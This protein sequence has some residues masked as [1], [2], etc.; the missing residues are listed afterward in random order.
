MA[1]EITTPTSGDDQSGGGSTQQTQVLGLDPGQMSA[2][3]I[4]AAKAKHPWWDGKPISLDRMAAILDERRRFKSQAEQLGG[5]TKEL[6]ELRAYRE[7]QERKG[8]TEIENLQAD[9]KKQAEER[10]K[11][12]AENRALRHRTLALTHGAKNPDFAQWYIE[13]EQAKDPNAAPEDIIAKMA[14]A[15]PD[16]F[17]TT[18]NG[19]DTSVVEPEPKAAAQGGAG[20]SARG[21]Q[22]MTLVEVEKALDDLKKSGAQGKKYTRRRWNLLRQREQLMNNNPPDREAAQRLKEEQAARGG[23]RSNANN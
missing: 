17:G 16:Q 22:G 20:A 3:E 19:G 6:E 8:R 21:E 5:T 15:Y 13:Q 7:E 18:G 11:L 14:V 12:A 4:A 10:A 2:Q 23:Q 9:L 1:D